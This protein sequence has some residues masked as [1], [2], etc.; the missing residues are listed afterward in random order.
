MR[1]VWLF[2]IPSL[3]VGGYGRW[4]S[5]GLSDE[6]IKHIFIHPSD[7][8]IIFWGGW[9]MVTI[10]PLIKV[11]SGNFSLR[12]SHLTTSFFFA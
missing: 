7:P 5:L 9:K 6:V 2:F 1:K 8:Q 4:E 12:T 3:V 10:G 11:K